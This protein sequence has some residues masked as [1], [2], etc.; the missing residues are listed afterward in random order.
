MWRRVRRAAL[1]LSPWVTLAVLVVPHAA[2][3]W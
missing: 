2:K 3:R 1:A